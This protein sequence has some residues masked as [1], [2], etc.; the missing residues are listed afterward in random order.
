MKME[1]LEYI[2]NCLYYHL[3]NNKDENPEHVY[4]ITCNS[5]VIIDKEIE[6]QSNEKTNRSNNT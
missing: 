2:R 3:I 6:N 1:Y 5:I 4:N